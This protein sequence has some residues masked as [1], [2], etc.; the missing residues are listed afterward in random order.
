MK[1]LPDYNP[2]PS[3]FDLTFLYESKIKQIED[4]MVTNPD[5]EASSMDN[6]LI[7]LHKTSFIVCW[8]EEVGRDQRITLRSNSCLE[9]DYSFNSVFDGGVS[10]L[11]HTSVL[12]G[13]DK[14]GIQFF[15]LY[16]TESSDFSYPDGQ[17]SVSNTLEILDTLS[18]FFPYILFILV[19]SLSVAK[20]TSL[21]IFS[22]ILKI[23]SPSQKY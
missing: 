14:T 6:L 1:S 5:T 13:L 10:E 2:I 21:G 15:Y 7:I 22:K 11:N 8:L 23:F 18:D 19:F 9:W 17:D 12:T 20:L 4:I 16:Q 3:N